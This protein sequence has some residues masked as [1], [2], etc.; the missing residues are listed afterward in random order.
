MTG[1]AITEEDSRAHQNAAKTVP[2]SAPPSA[3]ESSSSGEPTILTFTQIKELIEQG[4]TDLIPNNRH[5]PDAL[6]VSYLHLRYG[7]NAE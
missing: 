5:I 1:Y 3:P 4:K 7:K 2:D 6:N